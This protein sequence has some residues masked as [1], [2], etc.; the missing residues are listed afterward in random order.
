M[1]RTW[2]AVS[3]KNSLIWIQYV[4]PCQYYITLQNNITMAK[5]AKKAADKPTKTDKPKTQPKSLTP[6]EAREKFKSDHK[7][8]KERA[9][10]IQ[11]WEEGDSIE[12]AE[13]ETDTD[14]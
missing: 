9:E 7:K 6:N 5:S 10:G 11:A 14:E 2:P 12:C 4:N 3:L 8:A 13:D 1:N